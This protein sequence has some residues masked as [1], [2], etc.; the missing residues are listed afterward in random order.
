[1]SAEEPTDVARL[2]QAFAALRDDG[3]SEAVDSERIFDALHGDMSA[4]DRHAVVDQLLS[5]PAAAE[6]W[7]L[8]REMTPE[9]VGDAHLDRTLESRRPATWQWMSVAAAVLLAA[10]L[11]WQLGPWRQAGEPA[12]R[13][14]ESRAIASAI[15]GADVRRAQP[16]LRW[17]G[18]EGARYRVRVMTADLQLLH[19]SMEVATREYTIGPDVLARVAPG[20]Q[21]L[22]QVEAR[23]P[24]EGVITSPT[25]SNRVP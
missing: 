20:S 17:S 15:Q 25:F 23:I 10:G 2:R 24:G 14:V 19:E 16:V 3:T 13:G 7:R 22:W 4:E 18:A 11:G 12:Y 1:V 9:P 5:S 6:S 21:L 8:A